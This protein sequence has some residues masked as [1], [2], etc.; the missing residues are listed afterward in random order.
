MM[1][2]GVV[3]SHHI[4]IG[5]Q[6]EHLAN[7]IE[8]ATAFCRAHAPA[9]D[10]EAQIQLVA[11]EVFLNAVHHGQ[12]D[13]GG[14]NFV[15]LTLYPQPAG[16]ALVI[17]DSGLAFN[18]LTEAPPPDLDAVIEDRPVGGLGIMLVREMTDQAIYTRINNRNRL[19]LVFGP[20]PV[21]QHQEPA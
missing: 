8:W 5:A 15:W 4:R 17:E 14:D 11:E 19:T 9:K 6:S 12:S 18:P 3:E 7:I 10:R 16:A 2:S 21:P 1:G 13:G 20:G